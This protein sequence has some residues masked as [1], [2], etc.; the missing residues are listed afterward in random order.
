MAIKTR[1]AAVLFD[2]LA[3]SLLSGFCCTAASAYM[4][5][6]I[7]QFSSNPSQ[8][9]SP[10]TPKKKMEKEGT[11]RELLSLIDMGALSENEYFRLRLYVLTC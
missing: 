10:I 3:L 9:S 11:E 4:F 6:G 7:Y 5:S 1:S 8:L 2:Y